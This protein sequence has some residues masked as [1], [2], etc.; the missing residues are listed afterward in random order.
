MDVVRTL[1]ACVVMLAVGGVP[2]VGGQTPVAPR[3][4]EAEPKDEAE[5]YRETVVVTATNTAQPVGRVPASVSVMTAEDLRRTPVASLSEALVPSP[6]SNCRRPASRSRATPSSRFVAFLGRSALVL[7]DGLAAND[8][9]FGTLV[10]LD[11]LPVQGLERVEVVRGPFSS[12]HGANAFGGVMNVMTRR[13]SGRLTLEPFGAA[14]SAGYNQHGFT[15]Q[16]GGRASAFSL[17]ADQRH[18][19]NV[20]GRSS[21]RRSRLCRQQHPRRRTGSARQHGTTTCG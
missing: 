18:I 16:G 12:L 4:A 21:Q 13:G 2:T 9:G 19:D 7:V 15:A 20:Y 17:T 1:C 6:G 5:V 14:G 8:L 10:G 3:A 11:M